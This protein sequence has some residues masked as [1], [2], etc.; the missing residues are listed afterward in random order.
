MNYELCK[1]KHL[2]WQQ[3]QHLTFLKQLTI[4]LA[5]S[6]DLVVIYPVEPTKYLMLLYYTSLLF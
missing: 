4:Y 5:N 2:S 1:I 6:Q 3:L